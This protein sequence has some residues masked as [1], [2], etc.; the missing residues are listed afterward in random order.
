M[1]PLAL[2][3][4]MGAAAVGGRL[5][6]AAVGDGLSFAAELLRGATGGPAATPTGGAEVIHLREDL[7]ERIASLAGR[8]RQHLVAAGIE[9]SQPLELVSDGLSGIAVAGAHPQQAAIEQALGNDVLLLRDFDRLRRD[10]DQFVA[11]HPDADLFSAF[12]NRPEAGSTFAI[13]C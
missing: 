9:L 1:N 3:S 7:A 4:A 2:S 11:A 13:C 5:A 12:R 6:A 10:Y 8:I